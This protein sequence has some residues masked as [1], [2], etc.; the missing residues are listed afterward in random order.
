MKEVIKKQLE[1]FHK[2][3][4]GEKIGM[5]QMIGLIQPVLIKI[6]NWIVGIIFYGLILRH[7]LGLSTKIFKVLAFEAILFT[8]SRTMLSLKFSLKI[9]EFK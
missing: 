4:A 7:Q 1:D 5:M 6:W 3:K 2:R 9:L 8:F